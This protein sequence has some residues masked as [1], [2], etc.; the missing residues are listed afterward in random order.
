[1]TIIERCRQ[2]P[3]PVEPRENLCPP[4]AIEL[5]YRI[6]AAFPEPVIPTCE[7]CKASYSLLE[8]RVLR[9]ATDPRAGS[10]ETPNLCWVCAHLH[11]SAALS[12]TPMPK[13]N[14]RCRIGSM[15]ILRKALTLLA[16]VAALGLP[17]AAQGTDCASTFSFTTDASQTGVSNLSGQTPCVNWRVTYSVTGT[18]ASTV[19]FQTSPNNSNWTSVPNTV[20]TPTVQPPCILQGTNPLT[21]TTQ[22]MSYFS[23]Y[24]AWVRV[25]TTA[26]SGTG[27]GTVRLYGAKGATA[28]VA[29]PATLPNAGTVTDTL[30]PLTLN[31]VILGN[32]T[33]DVKPGA[34]L[35]NDAGKFYDGTGNF[36]PVPSTGQLVYYFTPTASSIA[37]YLQ[38]TVLPFSPKTTLSFTALATGTDVLKNWATNAGL[39]NL[40]F[41]PQGIYVQ[42]IH[43]LRTGGGTVTLHTQ[44]WEVDSAGVDIAMIGQTSD[45]P[46]LGTGEIEYNLDFSSSAVYTLA[47]TSSRIVGRVR[48]VVSG[49][50]PTVQIFV[51]G[52]ADSR[53]DLPS[54]TVDA[55]FFV[56]YIGATANVDLATYDIL[57]GAGNG[58]FGTDL[59]TGN[60]LPIAKLVAWGGNLV[61][62]D[63]ATLGA[64]SLTNGALTSGTSWSRTGDFAL[65]SNAAVYTHSAGTGTIVQANGTLAV[66]LTDNRWYKLVYTV[67][68]VTPGVAL[69]LPAA[70]CDTAFT[71]TFESTAGVAK[72]FYWKTAT[73]ASA[74]AFTI[75]GTS[76]AGGLTLDDLSL[77]EVQGGNAVVYG[78]ITGG[79]TTGI[80][81][82]SSG[83]VGI[84]TTAPT[85]K[86]DI[87]GAGVQRL[88]ITDTS[89]GA[90]FRAVASGTAAF[91]GGGTSTDANFQAG[92][93]NVI[94][95]NAATRTVNISTAGVFPNL[96]GLDVS[97]GVGLTGT[98]RFFDQTAATGTTLVTITP[99]AAQT[100]S[101]TV[102][103]IQALARFG[104]LNSTAA[105]AGVI[106]STCPAI[107]CTAAFTWVKAIA[108]DNSVVY[109]PVWK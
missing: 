103:D 26:S 53:M 84:G 90:I 15:S 3:A 27:T 44:F 82:S 101:S 68:A 80:K 30:G 14:F 62:G 102:L 43:A 33:N 16:L 86:I 77:K 48:A 88:T 12:S 13:K 98:A 4:H 95:I 57:T 94:N 29:T 37:T 50:A 97:S 100:T 64:E 66:V 67:S 61:V 38:G 2:C 34:V 9:E 25:I 42:H 19:T 11:L 6:M 96:Y 63:P 10:P 83:M 47:S 58:G 18:L 85:Q 49:S 39:P 23:A 32:G 41:I 74:L 21:G 8:A 72:V 56:P 109:F 36:S 71:C 5:A 104:G 92:G 46:A 24:G 35:P 40:S 106:G 59:R 78:L 45:T 20:C 76:T 51:G 17:L 99:G 89:G 105:V 87:Q 22:G 60:L 28:S 7:V 54:N 1:M 107:T 91:I 73:G 93:N 75:T 55:T 31:A 52:A 70:I 108:A 69:S 65:T 79:G 81:V